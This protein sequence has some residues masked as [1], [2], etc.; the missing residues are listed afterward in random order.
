MCRTVRRGA[1]RRL[2]TGA[3]HGELA[4]LV[5]ER[6]IVRRHSGD[7]VALA[8]LFIGVFIAALGMLGIAV[9]EVF[10]R[11]VRVFQTPPAIYL[12]AVIRGVF[13]VVLVLAAPVSRAPRVLSVLGFLIIMGGLLTPFVGLRGAEVVLEWWSAGGPAFVRLWAGVALAIGVF[14]VYA[15]ARRR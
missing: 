10:L 4:S 1:R 8:A 15:V 11:T 6:A 7:I 9:P 14:I 13:G 5:A 12:A 2:T 3:G